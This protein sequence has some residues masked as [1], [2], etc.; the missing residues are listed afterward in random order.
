[1]GPP[2]PPPPP[3]LQTPYYPFGHAARWVFDVAISVSVNGALKRGDVARAAAAIDAAVGTLRGDATFVNPDGGPRLLVGVP[4]SVVA[5]HRAG[6]PAR[7]YVHVTM[8]AAV[9]LPTCQIAVAG[10]LGP[11]GAIGAGIH[12]LDWCAGFNHAACEAYLDSAA[13]RPKH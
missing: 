9:D 3:A 7:T 2:P 4:K 1:M 11:T 6:P 10:V 12:V 5:T 8:R 13:E